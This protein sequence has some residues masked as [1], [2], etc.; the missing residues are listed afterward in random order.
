MNLP[1]Q[2]LV[3]RARAGERDA[4]EALFRDTHAR[5]YGLFRALGFSGDEAADLTQET[6]VKA[7]QSLNGLRE[8]EKFLS[9]LFRIA[10]NQ[11]KDFL[12]HRSRHPEQELSEA[13]AIA[14]P[15]A[16]SP[17]RAAES[18]E[19]ELEVRR[20]LSSLPED[21]RVPLVLHHFHGMPVSEIASVLGVPFGTVLS[22]MARARAAM[23]RRL[24]P[25]ME[26]GSP[27]AVT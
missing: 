24:A 15:A 23:A 13:R 2:I 20:A 11:A 26:T 3:E 18:G 25:L 14:A 10:R 21:Q 16:E 6:Y 12:K 4:F 5:I 7:W 22:R 17:E 8:P 9:W 19:L 27:G 1:V